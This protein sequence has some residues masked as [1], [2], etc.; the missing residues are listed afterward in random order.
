MEKE[1]ECPDKGP[2]LLSLAN[3][4]ICCL[5]ILISL[6]NLEKLCRKQRSFNTHRQNKGPCNTEPKSEI[7]CEHSWKRRKKRKIT[8][9]PSDCGPM[10][11]SSC[12]EQN[13]S[14]LSQMLVTPLPSL[15]WTLWPFQLCQDNHKISS[16]QI[17]SRQTKWKSPNH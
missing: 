14:T 15:R 6:V 5:I 10:G 2:F 7:V 8:F 17:L 11:S 13:F 3:L 4:L 9:A 16:S 1:S 12:A